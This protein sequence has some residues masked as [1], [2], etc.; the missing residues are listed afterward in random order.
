MVSNDASPASTFLPSISDLASCHSSPAAVLD[1]RL[2]TAHTAQAVNGS[3]PGTRAGILGHFVDTPLHPAGNKKYTCNRH[4][5][6][7][8]GALPSF[9]A[10]RE[11]VLG[12][13]MCLAT[14]R[15]SFGRDF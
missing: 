8:H 4:D 12:F 10:G 11:S 14:D 15:I 7:Y 5:T 2:T 6:R 3:K 9:G 13:R 1:R